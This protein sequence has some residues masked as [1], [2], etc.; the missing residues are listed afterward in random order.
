MGRHNLGKAAQAAD[1]MLTAVVDQRNCI[2]EE[3]CLTDHHLQNCSTVCQATSYFL[4]SIP[5]LFS[6]KICF[7]YI[8]SLLIY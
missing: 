2:P 8:E 1:R 5:G 6:I 4:L 3:N 7:S